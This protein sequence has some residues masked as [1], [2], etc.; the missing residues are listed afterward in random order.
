MTLG[1]S[2]GHWWD[3]PTNCVERDAEL[4]RL[5]QVLGSV[6]GPLAEWVCITGAKIVR[7]MRSILLVPCITIRLTRQRRSSHRI[8]NAQAILVARSGE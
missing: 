5:P 3:F 7:P 4:A 2:E 8:R 1:L 6:V